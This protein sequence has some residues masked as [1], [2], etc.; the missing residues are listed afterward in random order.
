MKALL[1][2]LVLLLILSLLLTSDEL[3]LV[4]RRLRS[5]LP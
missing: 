3:V 1:Q 2:I 5:H 4:L